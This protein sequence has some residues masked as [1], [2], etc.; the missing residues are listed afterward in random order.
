MRHEKLIKVI[1]FGKKRS[2][3]VSLIAANII[4]STESS[5]ETAKQLIKLISELIKIAGYKVTIQK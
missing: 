1:T 3:T 4:V 2:A 5:K